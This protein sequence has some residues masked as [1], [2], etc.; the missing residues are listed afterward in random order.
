[1]IIAPAKSFASCCVFISRSLV[2]ASNSGYS[3]ASVLKS[4]LNGGS[5]PTDSFL[6]SLPY[7]TDLTASFVFLI[8]PRHG[9][10]RQN[11]VHSHMLTVSAGMCLRHP[12]AGCVTPISNVMNSRFR[13]WSSLWNGTVPVAPYTEERILLTLHLWSP[14]CALSPSRCLVEWI[15]WTKWV[16]CKND[17]YAR[18]N[19]PSSWHEACSAVSHFARIKLF[20]SSCE[21]QLPRCCY[22]W[23]LLLRFCAEH[24]ETADNY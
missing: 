17:H 19:K 22:V 2:T 1:M 23:L 15:F 21:T 20:S 18:T 13:Q 3:S 24:C 10:R 9:Q 11:T 4:S 14:G 8:Y 6:H 5:L 12:V 16:S 7:R